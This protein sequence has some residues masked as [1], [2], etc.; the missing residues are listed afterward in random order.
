MEFASSRLFGYLIAVIVLIVLVLSMMPGGFIRETLEKNPL[1]GVPTDV[2]NDTLA[3]GGSVALPD[4][5]RSQVVSLK[6]T[7]SVMLA[8]SKTRCFGEYTA[9][10]ALDETSLT[11]AQRQEGGGSILIVKA[12]A[13]GKQVVTDLSSEYPT[14]IPCVVSGGMV[15]SNFGKNFLA[16]PKQLVEG[17]FEEVSAITV[18][19]DDGGYLGST[20]NRINFGSGFIDFNDGGFLYKP[21]ENHI[22]FFPT[23]SGSSCEFDSPEG[24]S[25]GCLSSTVEASL[26]I[27]RQLASGGLI[28]CS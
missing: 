5:H 7:I 23:A 10:S 19:L 1:D 2:L 27:P 26:A 9:F 28:R 4:E 3:Q 24:I 21:D 14:L 20:H 22:C 25:E 18:R 17:H 11:L 15:V 16:D 6:E 8:S 13:G 12:G